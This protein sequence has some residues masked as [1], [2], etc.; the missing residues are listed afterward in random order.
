MPG[1]D[2]CCG[3]RDR[4]S[5]FYFGAFVYRPICRAKFSAQLIKPTW[6]YARGKL[7]S[8]PP[9]EGIDLFSP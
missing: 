3:G 4:R 8:M 9:G 1:C 5:R 6:L 2:R 7:S